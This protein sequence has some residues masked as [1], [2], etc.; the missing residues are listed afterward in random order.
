MSHSHNLTCYTYVTIQCALQATDTIPVEV[1]LILWFMFQ[2]QMH[3]IAISN[4]VNN[5]TDCTY[6]TCSS[7]K[8]HCIEY[9]SNICPFNNIDTQ[10]SDTFFK[11]PMQ[12]ENGIIRLLMFCKCSFLPHTTYVLF[13]YFMLLYFVD[14]SKDFLVIVR[15]KFTHMFKEC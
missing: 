9:V 11:K 1:N 7:N 3:I 4:S 15:E 12:F 8:W 6:A 10:C 5:E 13:I 2:I 14:C